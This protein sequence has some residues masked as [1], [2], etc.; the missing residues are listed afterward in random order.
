M[1]NNVLSS[2]NSNPAEVTAAQRRVIE[3]ARGIFDI[4]LLDTA[5]LLS[6]NDASELISVADAGGARRPCRPH[7]QAGRGPGHRGAP[8]PR[9]HRGRRGP[10]RRP[11]RPERAVL[12]LRH[13]GGP[14]P[15]PARGRVAPARPAGAGPTGSPAGLGRPAASA[16]APGPASPR[17]RRPEAL[18]ER[19]EVELNGAAGGPSGPATSGS[20]GVAAPT[21]RTN[22]RAPGR[23]PRPPAA[24][25][26]RWPGPGPASSTGPGRPEV[27]GRSGR[28]PGA[29]P[30]GTWSGSC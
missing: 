16:S 18:G 21:S 7:H 12:L 19:L 29:P 25:G 9:G 2:T 10:A 27:A 4:I 5:P 11:L 6:T 20:S 1:V 13:R 3:A 14:R 8:T 22:D 30:T 17:A 26:C 24:I 23:R 15:E 28:R